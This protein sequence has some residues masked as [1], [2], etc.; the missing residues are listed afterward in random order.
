MF[1]VGDIAKF[2]KSMLAFVHDFK[3]KEALKDAKKIT[4]LIVEVDD[5]EKE[6]HVLDSRGQIIKLKYHDIEAV[7][8]M[9]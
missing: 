6:V 3:S 9:V 1:C 4:F 5:P 8:K 7:Q 2:S